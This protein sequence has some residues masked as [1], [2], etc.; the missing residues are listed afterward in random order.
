M[1]SVN[2]DSSG[3]SEGR[4]TQSVDSTVVSRVYG[5]GRGWV[6]TPV[7]L[8]VPGSHIPDR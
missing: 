5:K 7:W 8:S 1:I 2:G 4:H 3:R 6:F